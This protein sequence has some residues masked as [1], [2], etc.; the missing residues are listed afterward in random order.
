MQA[1]KTRSDRAGPHNPHHPLSGIPGVRL[2]VTAVLAIAMAG[3]ANISIETH[4]ETTTTVMQW[5]TSTQTSGGFGLVLRASATSP[6][7]CT[8][9]IEAGSDEHAGEIEH[10]RVETWNGSAFQW[11]GAWAGSAMRVHAG[12]AATG[13]S[14]ST[15]SGSWSSGHTGSWNGSG[16]YELVWAIADYEGP[17]RVDAHATC[18]GATD[19][20]M[21][22]SHDAIVWSH[23]NA[24]EGVGMFSWDPDG[25]RS[26]GAAVGFE[27][28]SGQAMVFAAATDGFQGELMTTTPSGERTDDIDG[29]FFLRE[30]AGAGEYAQKLQ[31]LTTEDH[32]FV[33]AWVPLD[34]G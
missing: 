29:D 22:T 24:P 18:S 31:H 6:A 34:R 1:V 7:T 9:D 4:A 11:S 10:L 16:T 26:A 19:A 3:C 5:S 30:E 23:R 13:G 17:Y 15:G 33:G 32:F 28:S 14:V 21:L 12:P 8:V 20:E 27:G 25:L 2:L